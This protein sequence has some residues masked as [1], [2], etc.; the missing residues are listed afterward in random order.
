MSEQQQAATA[1][2]LYRIIRHVRPLYRHLYRAVE[3]NLA[4]SGVS[5]MM[6]A[7]MEE[8]NEQGPRTVPQIGRGLALPRQFAQRSVND[9]R[10]LGLVERKANP[11]HRRSWLVRLTDRGR[12]TFAA[13]MRREAAVLDGVAG[14]LQAD[15]VAACRR[16][17]AHMA[18]SFATLN[19]KENR[20]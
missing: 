15:E 1:A 11:A 14:D 10:R 18:R 17:I 3:D 2:E 7:V 5:V 12:I 13:I 4:G 8:L 6:R 20:T 16:V 19:D 9:L